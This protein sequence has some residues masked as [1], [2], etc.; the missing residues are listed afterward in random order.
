MRKFKTMQDFIKNNHPDYHG[1]KEIFEMQT[2][3]ILMDYCVYGNEFLNES[4]A[5]MLR[6]QYKGDKSNPQ[7]EIDRHVAYIKCLEAAIEA[8]H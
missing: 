2:L 6:E 1:S 7:I 8:L 3:E 5:Q 4:A